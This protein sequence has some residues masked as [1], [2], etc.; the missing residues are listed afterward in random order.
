MITSEMILRRTGVN[1]N[2][3]EQ[4]S[5]EWHRLRLGVIT[6]SEASKVISKP[7]SGT[8]WPDMKQTYFYTL[9]GEICTSESP[10]VNA[11]A[12]AWGKQHEES[13]RRLF[14]FTANVS[15]IEAPILYRDEAMRTACSPD[16]L[17]SD[18]RGLE[19]K[20]PFTSAVFM[21]FLLGGL[22]AI[23]SEYMAQVQYSMWVT[24]KDGWYFGN[25]DPR[26]KREGIHHIII[27]RDE[28]YMSDFNEMVPEFIEKMDES[29]AEIGF[30]FGDQ[31]R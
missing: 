13:A 12:L 5:S 27:E 7:R 11:K 2:L 30:K 6:A 4:G 17:C 21:K 25:Y 28:K 31:W 19:L 15:V 8:K 3:I 29:L 22:E 20:C 23:K 18:G 9:L 10:E 14:E 24:G 1:I 16:G 26:M